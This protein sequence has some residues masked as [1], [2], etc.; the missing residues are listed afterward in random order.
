MFQL[1]TKLHVFQKNPVIMAK[2]DACTEDEIVQAYHEHCIREVLREF[3]SNVL[4]QMSHGELEF[5][6]TTAL[7][8]AAGILP[9]AR[10]VDQTQII[11]S[12]VVNKFGDAMK[13]VQCHA[14]NTM[15]RLLTRFH[16]DNK[17]EI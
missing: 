10:Q 5:Q 13:K 12:Q 4:P 9:Y 15:V 3:C 8:L 14:I 16:G 1:Q 17:E 6:K 7:D 2:Q 11:I